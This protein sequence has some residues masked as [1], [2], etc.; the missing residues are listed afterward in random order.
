MITYL[1]GDATNPQVIGNK[2]IIHICN[3]RGGWDCEPLK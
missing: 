2:A 1:K 3:G